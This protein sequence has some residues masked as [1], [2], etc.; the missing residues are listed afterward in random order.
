MKL[1]LNKYADFAKYAEKKAKVR[2]LEKQTALLMGEAK[3]ILKDSIMPSIEKDLGIK[4]GDIVKFVGYTD[5]GERKEVIGVYENLENRYGSLY[6]HLYKV[7]KDGSR[8]KF[9]HLF[10]N[11]PCLNSEYESFEVEVLGREKE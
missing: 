9:A 4:K 10:C 6:P 11:V 1:E 8:G 5:Y 2:E 3:R 7:K